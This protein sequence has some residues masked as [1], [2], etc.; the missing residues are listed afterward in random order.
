[1]TKTLADYLEIVPLSDFES[2]D[3]E[4]LVTISGKA[5]D[6][7]LCNNNLVLDD[8]PE[9]GGRAGTFFKQ[10]LL[11]VT[12]KLSPEQRLVYV[13]RRP[14][15]VLLFTDAREPVLWGNAD[16]KLRITITP[17][18]DADILNFNRKALSPVF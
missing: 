8:T 18:P 12:D 10:S 1:M 11:A 3:G 4:H 13:P 6:H 15:I 16:E 7:I 2:F 17:T 14:V 9:T 5:P